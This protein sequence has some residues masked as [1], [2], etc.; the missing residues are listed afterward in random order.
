VK[1]KKLTPMMR[2]YLQA[3]SEYPDA[4]VFFRMGDFYE[5]FFEDAEIASP[6]NRTFRN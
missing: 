1:G 2:Q 6:H 5:M 3:K 4:I